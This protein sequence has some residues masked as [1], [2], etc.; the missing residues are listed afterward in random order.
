MTTAK[1]HT[2]QEKKSNNNKKIQSS[3]KIDQGRQRELFTVH[4]DVALLLSVSSESQGPK[5]T[6]FVSV[7]RK[8]IK[9]S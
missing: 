8:E 5:A 7:D 6:S 2:K 4:C 3:K 9:L 1:Q